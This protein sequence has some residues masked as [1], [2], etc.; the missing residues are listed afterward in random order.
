MY[1]TVVTPNTQDQQWISL[2]QPYQSKWVALDEQKKNILSYGTSYA[3]VEERLKEEHKEADS[4]MYITPFT[5]YYA[6]HF[7]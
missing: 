7:S 5:S 1:M 4:I 3:E 6:P 2:I